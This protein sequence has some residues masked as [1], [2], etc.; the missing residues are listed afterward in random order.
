MKGDFFY[1]LQWEMRA[2][3]GAI[4]D[5]AAASQLHAS[6]PYAKIFSGFEIAGGCP[7]T[8]PA[9]DADDQG[10]DERGQ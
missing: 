1:H 2:T 6:C 10:I 8:Q 5:G 9:G 3:P 7:A 4:H